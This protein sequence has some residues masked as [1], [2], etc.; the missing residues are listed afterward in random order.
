M[1][2]AV[3][4][5]M[6]TCVRSWLPKWMYLTRP[7]HKYCLKMYFIYIKSSNFNTNVLCRRHTLAQARW[8][9]SICTPNYIHIFQRPLHPEAYAVFQPGGGQKFKENKIQGA[10]FFVFEILYIYIY[11]YMSNFLLLSAVAR[12]IKLVH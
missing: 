9:R 1:Q 4:Y 2:M 5:H 11:I 12:H 6:P 7:K 8:L 3:V 10:F